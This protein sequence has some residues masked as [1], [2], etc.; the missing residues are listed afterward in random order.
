MDRKNVIFLTVVAIAT[1]LVAVVGATFAYFS[2]TV[3]TNISGN[4]N[5]ASV[6]TAK[7]TS[8]TIIFSASGDRINMEDAIPGDTATAKF[9]IQNNGQ[10]DIPYSIKWTDVNN[11]FSQSN[12]DSDVTPSTGNMEDELVYSMS[13]SGGTVANKP[14]TVAPLSDGDTNAV[15]LS[16]LTVT[17]GQTATCTLTV[18]FKETN[19]NQNYNQ[20][21]NFVGTVSV[22]TDNITANNTTTGN[23]GTGE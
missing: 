5:Q 15:I 18:T 4:A 8:S 16:N 14:E 22:S 3:Q 6:G 19:T 20:G 10:T 23:A 12:P 13:C 11:T 17:A 2:T 7:Y 21:K 1:L 9:E